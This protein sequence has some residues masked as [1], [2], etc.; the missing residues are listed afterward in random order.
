MTCRFAGNPNFATRNPEQIQNP[1]DR[2]GL[3][4][5]L[6]LEFRLWCFGVVS[7]FEL[8][9]SDLLGKAHDPPGLR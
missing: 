3:L 8:R 6:G 7:D 2:N 4:T 1:K 9:I 5:S